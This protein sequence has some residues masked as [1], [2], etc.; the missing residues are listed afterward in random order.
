VVLSVVHLVRFVSK[1]ICYVFLLY[2]LLFTY[3]EFI[4]MGIIRFARSWQFTFI[5]IIAVVNVVMGR[6]VHVLD[7]V[8]CF[9]HNIHMNI[10]NTHLGGRTYQCQMECERGISNTDATVLESFLDF[11][12][13]LIY[14]FL[15]L[16][17]MQS[18]WQTIYP[19]TGHH[20][21]VVAWQS[22]SESQVKITA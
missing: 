7:T 14:F 2:I 10:W 20:N 16:I 19:R 11:L 17:F 5:E 4:V 9:K 15:L 18:L 3:R 22:I 6:I 8:S 12:F 1:K 21:L 13:E